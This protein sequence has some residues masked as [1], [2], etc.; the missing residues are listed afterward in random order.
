MAQLSETQRRVLLRIVA[1]GCATL[2]TW[3][4]SCTELASWEDGFFPAELSYACEDL[5]AK[6]LIA[7]IGENYLALYRPTL[8][9]VRWVIAWFEAFIAYPPHEGCLHE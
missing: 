7:D 6:G 5:T 2:T 9:G 1:D 3:G 8:A 4:S